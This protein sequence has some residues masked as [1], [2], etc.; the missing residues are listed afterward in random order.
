M[1]SILGAL[2][3]FPFTL[4]A[5]GSP[6]AWHF[7]VLAGA[8]VVGRQP[9]TGARR[10]YHADLLGSVRAVAAGATVLESADYDPWGLALPGRTL[11][12]GTKE[13]FAGQERD[14]ETGL[15]HVEARAYLPALGRW[16]SVDPLAAAYAEWSP[17]AYVLNDPAR[18]VDRK[19]VV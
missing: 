14:A 18:L 4:D 16:G 9:H 17:Y 2:G 11:G 8:R 15:D 10:H 1:N 13:G 19:S 7:N 5:A 3:T 6:S 12:G